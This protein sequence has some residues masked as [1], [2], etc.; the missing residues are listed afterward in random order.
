MAAMLVKN[1]P[2]IRRPQFNSWVGK[3]L[4]KGIG[5]PLQ[6]SW[7]SLVAQMAKNPPLRQQKICLQCGRPGFKP[8]V[9]KIPGGGHGNPLQYSC[10]ENPHGQNNLAGYS[11]WG[12]KEVDT[13][14]Q[15]ST[16]QHRLQV[17]SK[18]LAAA[19]WSPLC[20]LHAPINSDRQSLCRQGLPGLSPASSFISNVLW[21]TSP[22][23]T[24]LIPDCVC[25]PIL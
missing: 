6:Y 21:V 11:P 13:T 22:S 15:L 19:G 8:W 25:P 9:G 12:C 10:L 4:G 20:S 17:R 16:V 7:T 18:G 14:E 3:I 1:P 23:L 24:F 2:V 5:Y